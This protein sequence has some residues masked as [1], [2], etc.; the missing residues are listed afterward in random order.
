[1]TRHAS[2]F[3]AALF[4]MAFAMT[5]FVP[6]ADAGYRSR[7]NAAIGIVGTAAAL[8]IIAGSSRRARADDDDDYE[9]RRRTYYYSEGGGLS[10]RSLRH[11]C[12]DGAGWACRKY[13]RRC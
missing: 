1:M 9:G 11:R 13:D 8:A 10:C 2:M 4:A 12:E 5:A 6:D 3:M 7:R